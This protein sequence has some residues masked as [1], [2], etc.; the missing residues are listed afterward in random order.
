MLRKRRSGRP[1]G[2]RLRMEP[3]IFSRSPAFLNRH[4]LD[5]ISTEHPILFNPRA[6]EQRRMAVNTKALEVLGIGKNTTDPEG[7]EIVRDEEGEPL[8]IL[9]ETARY[10]AYEKQPAK[11]VEEIK[12]LLVRAMD[13]AA[14]VGITSVQSDDFETF[15]DKDWRKS[16][17]GLQRA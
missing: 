8:G 12:E 1:V 4:D 2:H 9:R 15:S 5:R 6:D 10:L 7:G 11:S 14:A 16:G 3:L 13:E 17:K